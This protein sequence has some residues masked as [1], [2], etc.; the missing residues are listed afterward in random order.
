MAALTR[1]PPASALGCDCDH[2]LLGFFFFRMTDYIFFL[3][4]MLVLNVF[5]SGLCNTCLD[6]RVS[7]SL[8]F[9]FLNMH[10]HKFRLI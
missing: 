8:L 6:S 2:G 7:V 4:K 5:L 1:L 10:P 3:N 9:L